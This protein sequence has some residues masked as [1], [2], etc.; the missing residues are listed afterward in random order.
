METDSVIFGQDQLPIDGNVMTMHLEKVSFSGFHRCAPADC[1][2]KDTLLEDIINHSALLFGAEGPNTST[3]G[4][5]SD[6][7][8]SQPD[9]GDG[10]KP[11]SSRTRIQ[12]VAP[13]ESAEHAPKPQASPTII[14]TT[15]TPMFESADPGMPAPTFTP[16][17]QLELMFDP[18]VIP[19]SMRDAL[20]DAY[21]VSTRL[22]SDL[23]CP[24]VRP[25]ASTDL[26]RSHFDLLATLT[27]APPI[28]PSVYAN[29]FTHLK[30]CN[31]TYY[32]LVVIDKS[33]D[34]MIAHGAVILEQKYI[35]GGASAGHIEDIVVDPD[36]RGGGVGKKLVV[37]L[38][39]LA[40]GL[41]AYKVNLGCK[42]DRIREC[43]CAPLAG[44]TR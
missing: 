30:S 35:H 22:R 17:E 34:Q 6:V 12:I 11:G 32:I 39:D 23:I 14:K 36:V 41:G 18:A 19:E 31:G 16:D 1:R 29:L 7:T 27:V 25:L 9:A 5:P 43:H 4:S 33:N 26:M 28:A 20:G 3:T 15:P 21:H 42:E 8:A 44:F 40:I 38:R 2:R 24:Q 13:G 37:G 10:A